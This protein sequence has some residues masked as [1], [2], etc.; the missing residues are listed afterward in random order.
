MI[1]VDAS[2]L[3][4]GLVSGGPDG[5]AVRQRLRGEVVAAPE[6]VDL[7]VLSV[8]RRGVRSGA[9]D[10]RLAETAIRDLQTMPLE[11]APHRAL[12]T[13]CWELRNN[14]TPYDAC[15]VALAEALDA[16]LVTGDRRLA[17]AP[18]PRC[19]IE[20]VQSSQ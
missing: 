4:V 7:E 5:H 2:A 16:V 3:V 19:V 13:R 1:V 11:R 18:G 17:Q 10:P 12:T 14:L 6:L 20:M 9:V 15:Y 8:L